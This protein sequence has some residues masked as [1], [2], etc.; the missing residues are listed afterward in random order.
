MSQIIIESDQHKV[1]RKIPRKNQRFSII[2]NKIYLMNKIILFIYFYIVFKFID[3]M[4]LRVLERERER[5]GRRKRKI[6]SFFLY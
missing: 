1:D 2:L 3:S 4:H 5:K 6:Y